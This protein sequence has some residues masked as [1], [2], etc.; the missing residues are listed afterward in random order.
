[1]A[2]ID[3]YNSLIDTLLSRGIKPFM[4]ISQTIS[5]YD[6]PEELQQRYKGWLSPEIE[7]LDMGNLRRKVWMEENSRWEIGVAMNT[8]WIEPINNS[9]EDKKA[10]ERAQSFYM[11]W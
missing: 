8:K 1:M 6:I 2:G 3:Y 9:S 4:T 7:C 10:V 11:N 5:H